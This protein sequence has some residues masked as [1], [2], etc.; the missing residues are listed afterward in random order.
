MQ[1]LGMAYLPDPVAAADPV[2]RKYLLVCFLH[3]PSRPYPLARRTLKLLAH[4]QI[5]DRWD[6]YSDYL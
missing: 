6:I 5:G 1:T 2:M 4:P 3:Y